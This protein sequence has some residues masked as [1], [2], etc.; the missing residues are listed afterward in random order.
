MRAWALQ[1]GTLCLFVV[2]MMTAG[3][4]GT[5][6]HYN[7]VSGEKRCTVRL[8][9]EPTGMATVLCDKLT[10]IALSNG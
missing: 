9:E 8:D 3:E 4:G 10:C 1:G 2:K 6:T 7:L 5:M